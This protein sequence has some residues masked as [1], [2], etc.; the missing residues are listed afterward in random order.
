IFERPRPLSRQRRANHLYTLICEEPLKRLPQHFDLAPIIERYVNAA[1]QFASWFWEEINR[2]ST[3]LIDELTT[4]GSELMAWYKENV[5]PPEWLTQ[6][7]GSPPPDWNGRKWKLGLRRDR[8]ELGTRGFRV[9][10]VD[11]HGVV[12]L[13][14]DDDW[15]PLRLRYY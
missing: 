3:E 7:A 2:R 9:W 8:Y 14:K 4:K 1:G 13:Q 11:S 10:T 15:T 6:P 5:G 12:I